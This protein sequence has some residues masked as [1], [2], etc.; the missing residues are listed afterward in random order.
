ME[1]KKVTL[2]VYMPDNIV[3]KD[4]FNCLGCCLTELKFIPLEAI[5]YDDEKAKELLNILR[6]KKIKLTIERGDDYNGTEKN[7]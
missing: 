3:F 1:N 6:N 2:D 4:V 5:T 7:V